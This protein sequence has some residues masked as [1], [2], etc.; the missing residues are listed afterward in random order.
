[1]RGVLVRSMAVFGVGAAILVGILYYAST[2]DARPPLVLSIGVT[3][4]LSTD[5]AVAL[6]T[7]SIEVVFSEPVQPLTA[8]GAFRISPATRG[9][10]SWSEWPAR[11]GKR[12][13]PSARSEE[14]ASEL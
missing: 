9:A 2:V 14:H 6:T 8:E 10:F 4:H 1:M 11:C 5:S 13:R 3:Q 7:T 12:P